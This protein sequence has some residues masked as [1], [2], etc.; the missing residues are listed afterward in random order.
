MERQPAEHEVEVLVGERKTVSVRLHEVQVAQPCLGSLGSRLVQHLRRDVDGRDRADIRCYGAAQVSRARGN[1][2]HETPTARGRS[3][4]SPS[5]RYHERFERRIARGSMTAPPVGVRLVSD[6]GQSV[7]ATR[8]RTSG[9]FST[10]NLHYSANPN[11]ED[12]YDRTSIA[13]WPGGSR[14]SAPSRSIRVRG[15][16]WLRI[17]CGQRFGIEPE[18]V[19]MR[20]DLPAML[21]AC[22]V[23]LLIGGRGALHRAWP[24]RQARSGGGVDRHDGPA[25]RLVFLDRPRRHGASGRSA[26]PRYER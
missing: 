17:L 25:V 26:T 19:T 2:E 5:S 16:R 14:T 15:P 9:A 7:Q 11:G 22:D 10:R 21:A 20:P 24:T 8:L 23:A 12:T 6:R 3:E 18:F 13:L 1:I 4:S